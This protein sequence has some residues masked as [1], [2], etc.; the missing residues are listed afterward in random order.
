MK[1][2]F[3][4][5]YRPQIES[6]EY[7]VELRDGTPVKIIY[8]EAKGPSPIIGLFTA[9]DGTETT[10]QAYPNGKWS[11]DASYESSYD[12][13]V[14]ITPEEELT[15]FENEFG[16]AMME[17]PEPEEKEEW[18]QFLKEKSAELLDLAR[19]ALVD[20]QTKREDLSFSRGLRQGREGA[21]KSPWIPASNPPDDDR[22]VFICVN[23]NGI[24]QCVGCGCYKQGVW[25]DAEDKLDYPDYWMDIPELPREEE[26]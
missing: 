10:T 15:D 2:P 16:R 5:K 19:V 21:K 18:Y 3:D 8:W 9:D 7:K 22:L 11:E 1:I 25:V 24:A 23:D 20:E 6:G 4:I 12:L 17:V 13:F 14:I 26:L